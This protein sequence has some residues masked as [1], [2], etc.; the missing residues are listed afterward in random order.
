MSC[1]CQR[2]LNP[3][4]MRDKSHAEVLA[5]TR[6]EH[7]LDTPEANAKKA[8]YWRERRGKL[9]FEKAREIRNSNETCAALAEKYHVH[10]S[11]ISRVKRGVSWREQVRGSS[12]FNL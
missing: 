7:R 2:C 6:K 5:I 4:H 3:E 11:L 10:A 8:A 9:D 1:R 12:I